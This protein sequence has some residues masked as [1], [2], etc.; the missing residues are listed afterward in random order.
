MKKLLLVILILVMVIA[1]VPVTASTTQYAKLEIIDGDR[2]TG[3]S[4]PY[5]YVD[6][7]Y[8]GLPVGWDDAEE[9]YTIS[10][11][12]DGVK[13][14]DIDTESM[15][16]GITHIGSTVYVSL[17]DGVYKYSGG[18]LK[19]IAKFGEGLGW[20]TD[21]TTNGK[22]LYVTCSDDQFREEYL[23]A[24]QTTFYKVTT[25][26]KVTAYGKQALFGWLWS[27]FSFNAD[28]DRMSYAPFRK[29]N[30]RIQRSNGVEYI[31]RS[32]DSLDYN[33]SYIVDA[34]LYYDNCLLAN[35]K[36][37]LVYYDDKNKPHV[38]LGDMKGG[39]YARDGTYQPEGSLPVESGSGDKVRIGYVQCWDIGTDGCI[40]GYTTE[41]YMEDHWFKLTIPDSIKKVKTYKKVK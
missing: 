30:V 28:G 25:D 10:F 31:Q 17:C 34:V 22:D 13:L 32:Q 38:I 1:T 41:N 27:S 40:Y 4:A 3:G 37:S 15:N 16:Q 7:H 35:V 24:Y 11:A 23:S 6:G 5:T 18:A 26:G 12:R 36:G 20:I 39:I 8:Y 21:L 9:V 33:G 29:N 19:L 2:L 14:F